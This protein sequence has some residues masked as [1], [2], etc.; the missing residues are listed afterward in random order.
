[1]EKLSNERRLEILC[2]A[3]NLFADKGFERTTVD[4]IAGHANV[5]KGTVYLYFKNKEAI[6]QAIIE[7]GLND[8]EQILTEST[9]HSD[10]GRQ[11]HT[12]IL[13]NLKYI[14][15]NREFYRMFLKEGLTFKLLCD[16]QSYR[17]IMKKHESL[18]SMMRQVI[19]QGI[20]QGYLRPGIP[21]DYVA[22]I[23]GILNHFADHWI[24]SET[25]EP[26]TAKIEIIT[27][28]ILS[29]IKNNT[30]GGA[31]VNGA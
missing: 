7:Q 9:K 4:E 6:F 23:S 27:E 25:V 30:S 3:V 19:Q 28:I 24:M 10:F 31:P 12:I 1:L 18:F 26:M 20:E 22:A 21:D 16:E 8:L 5:G 15:S 29:G 13:N 2:A 17:L 14:E 11:L